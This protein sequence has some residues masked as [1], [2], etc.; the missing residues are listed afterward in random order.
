MR[1]GACPAVPGPPVLSCPG[2]RWWCPT[3]LAGVGTCGPVSYLMFFCAT[4]SSWSGFLRTAGPIVSLR[5]PAGKGGDG[6]PGPAPC[7]A[8]P[9]AWHSWEEPLPA[10]VLGQGACGPL[11][12]GPQLVCPLLGEGFCLGGPLCHLLSP[13]TLPLTRWRGPGPSLHGWLTCETLRHFA[14]AVLNSCLRGP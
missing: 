4:F 12:M 9:G 14:A 6:H 1:L 3:L 7:P 10:A 8:G 13:G 11:F 5:A 2:C